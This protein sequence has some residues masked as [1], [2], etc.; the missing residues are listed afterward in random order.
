MKRTTIILI[1]GTCLA[2]PIG[3]H[4]YQRL[5][6][7]TRH[8]FPYWPPDTATIQRH[9]DAHAPLTPDGQNRARREALYAELFKNRYRQH[10]PQIAVGMRILPGKRARLLCPA[11]MEPWELDQLAM[12]AWREMRTVLGQTYEI[13]IYET[14]IGAIP[15]RIAWLRPMPD[16]PRIARVV[17][18]PP[19]QQSH[20]PTN[21]RRRA[22][23]MP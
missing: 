16:N 11:R 22:T 20:G 10:Q 8:T 21:A 23:W 3:Y 7:T 5:Q 13:D 15:E 2:A 12:M 17:H 9:L 6:A 18:I 19:G 4:A 14:Y 1:L